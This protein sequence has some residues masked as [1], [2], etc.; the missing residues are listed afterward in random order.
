MNIRLAIALN[1]TTLALFLLS[2][3]V[4]AQSQSSATLDFDGDGRSDLVT[5]LANGTALSWDLTQS[6]LST[7]PETRLFQL[8]TDIPVPG[9]WI[10]PNSAQ[11]ATVRSDTQTR[12][13]LWKIADTNRTVRTFSF[14]STG[15]YIA[16]GG[17]FDGNGLL[18]AVSVSPVKQT[19]RWT[20]RKNIAVASSPKDASF[21]FGDFGDRIFF[22]HFGTT[23]DLPALFTAQRRLKIRRGT[24]TNSKYIQSLPLPSYLIRA[25]VTPRPFRIP[26]TDTKV[27]LIGFLLSDGSDTRFLV[28]RPRILRSK[29]TV[30]RLLDRT[31]VGTGSFSVG[32]YAP[33]LAGNEVVFLTNGTATLINPLTKT[34]R[35]L[36]G[37]ALRGALVNAFG[38][39]PVP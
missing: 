12:S 38:V 16:Y 27:D 11:L 9:A 14:G 8:A 20:I 26:S 34:I 1:I 33:E 22:G 21:I 5:T 39:G 36:D 31:L 29:V 13:I 15:D 25:G 18:D 23:Y 30:T 4:S 17:D 24:A 28:Y 2:Y 19:F 10:S 37:Q 3:G 7:A 35:P 32:N 6:D